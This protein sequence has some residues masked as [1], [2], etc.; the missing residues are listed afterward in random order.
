MADPRGKQVLGQLY[1]L[2]ESQIDKVFGGEDR[3]GASEDES[4]DDA[5]G[6]GNI[7]DMM[8]DT[9][10][11]SVLMFQQNMLPQTPEEMVQGFLQMFKK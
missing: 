9:P 5:L 3:Y 7:M 10:L 1:A 4:E 11:L 2:I 6:M 8:N